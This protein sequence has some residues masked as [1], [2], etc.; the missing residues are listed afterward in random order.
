MLPTEALSSGSLPS[1][2]YLACSPENVGTRVLRYFV[3]SIPLALAISF[4]SFYMIFS[5][6]RKACIERGVCAT[7]PYPSVTALD[8][9]SITFRRLGMFTGR[10]SHRTDHSPLYPERFPNYRTL[11]SQRLVG[12]YSIPGA[13]IQMPS[14]S[15]RKVEGLTTMGLADREQLSW[16]PDDGNIPV[17]TTLEDDIAIS[18]FSAA[19]PLSDGYCALCATT[20]HTLSS[21]SRRRGSAVS[22]DVA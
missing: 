19:L 13:L 21:V 4:C 17:F 8:A 18:G 10:T 1:L 9:Q 11:H 6:L 3:I 5:H 15:S 2:L 20:R 16:F 14:P 22:R 12:N 7:L